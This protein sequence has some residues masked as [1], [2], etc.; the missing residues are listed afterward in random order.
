MDELRIKI[1]LTGKSRHGKNRVKE[2]GEIWTLIREANIVSCCDGPA[3]LL[4][5]IRGELRWVAKQD[6]RNFKWEI[7][8]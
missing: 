4:R 8:K 6:D 5:N 2:Q 3:M 7:I 1:R